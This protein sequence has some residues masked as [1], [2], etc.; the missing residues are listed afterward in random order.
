MPA[1]GQFGGGG[2]SS[3]SP[4]Q[5]ANVWNLWNVRSYLSSYFIQTTGIDL[6]STDPLWL[7]DFHTDTLYVA[8]TIRKSGS[9]AYYCITTMTN[10]DGTQDPG[11]AHWGQMWEAS[12][13]WDPIG[14]QSGTD[15]SVAFTGQYNGDDKLIYNLYI[16]R[17]ASATT[18][19]VYPTDGED[20][21]GLFGFLTNTDTK[22][23]EIK[24]LGLVNPRVTGRRGTGS[25]VG[26][27]MNPARTPS[28]SYTVYVSECFAIPDAN[29][30]A[31]VK[32]FGATGGLVGANNSERKQK[33]PYIRYS[34]AKIPVSATHPANNT[35]NP[36]DYFGKPVIYNPY[37]IKY[38]GLVGCNENGVTQ[39]SFARGAISGG[40]RVGGLAGCTIDGAI[41]RSY[42][43]G[44]VTR[45]ITPGSWEGGIGGLVGRID[46]SLPPG[47]GGTQGTGSVQNAYWDNQTS[48][49]TSAGG[50]GYATSVMKD[51][52][53]VATNYVNWDF[54]NI[55]GF[56][57]G[58]N[59]NYPI[60]MGT[61][62]S[63]FY[64]RTKASSAWS[65][66]TTWESS[67]DNNTFSDAVV[68]PDLSNSVSILISHTVG[69][70]IDRTI[71]QSTIASTGKL[72]IN[73]GRTLLINNG[74]GTDLAINGE[75]IIT[76]TFSV[77]TSALVT[78]GNASLITFNGS[79]AQS[80]GT[81]FP[82]PVNNIT[83]NN[84]AGVTFDSPTGVPGV[85]VVIDGVLKIDSG[86]VSGTTD[87]DGY[88]SIDL[89]Y[90]EI[91]ETGTNI[92]GFSAS[93]SVVPGNFPAKIER[94]WS[95]S[96]TLGANKTLTFWWDA[97]DDHNYAWGTKVPSAYV[98]ASEYVSSTYN[99]S[100]DPRYLEISV[101]SF[102]GAKGSWTIGESNE[103]TLPVE[104]SSFT[105]TINAY[106]YVQIQWVT[107]SET[108][109]SGFRLYRSTTEQLYHA[110][111]LNVFIPATNTYHRRSIISL[112]ITN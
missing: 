63:V 18:N 68:V 9:N 86:Y 66:T 105:A 92:T 26:K 101:S 14:N 38:G 96:G 58:T 102:E 71:D 25:L 82:T 2:G 32:G 15:T 46:G 24:S 83:I 43:T 90:L 21:V 16:N 70:D 31:Y 19:D 87:T 98:G 103:E 69:L 11:T 30:T 17:G 56:T 81:G 3:G 10:N 41:F 23:T 85:P 5:V 108:N 109:L 55:W 88:H 33:V 61:P 94:Q 93:T 36:N 76:G 97:D 6:K 100:S 106:N 28:Y 51:Q 1:F 13:G 4:Y 65:L 104:L 22:N 79:A 84:A 20:N 39:D 73:S 110:D 75:L 91:D 67:P 50:T 27:V 112:P 107:Q 49:T 111:M 35:A 60:L 47:L 78:A 95:I 48:I 72:T 37:N 12:K 53:N 45:G 59:D 99:V 62:S 89:N 54:T 57:T 40:D 7:P 34:Y 77:G 64:Y 80:T 74:D 44:M 29:N 52:A 8:G 42:S